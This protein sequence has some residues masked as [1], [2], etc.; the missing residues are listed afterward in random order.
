MDTDVVVVGAGAAGLAAALWLAE[1]SVRVIVL[2]GRNN[3]GGRVMWQSLGT[4]DVPAEL[5]AEFVHGAAPETSALLRD[6][7][8]AKV[9]TGNAAWLC[10]SGRALRLDDDDIDS[11]AIFERAHS[12][13]ED[14]SVD[15]FLRRWEDDPR[16]REQARRA[17]AFVEGFEAADPGLASIRSIADEIRMGSDSTSSRPVGGYAPLFEHLTARC[18]RAGVDV[19]LGMVVERIAWKTGDVTIAAQTQ[20]G[21]A[22]EFRSRC[23]VITVPVGVLRAAGDANRFSFLPPLPAAKQAALRG[24]EMGH[25]VRVTLAFRSP[26]WEQAD[27]GRYRDAAFFRCEDGAFS[28]FWTQM[29]LRSRTIVA[30]AGGPRAT[31]LNGTPVQERIDRARDEFGAIFGQRDLARREYEAGVTHDWSTDPLAC[32]AYTYVATGAGAARAALGAPVDDTLFFAGEATSTDGQGGTVSGAFG[33]GMR[34][35]REAAR[36]FGIAGAASQSVS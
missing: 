32:G 36:A 11:R 22:S 20:N 5:G 1:R 29:P 3:V 14:E 28:A 35:A 21:G 24:L 25:A 4:A 31:A 6:A 23:A 8:L 18:V 17:R 33:T 19:R 10:S 34:A 2:E 7:G 26:F 9:E 27:D 12:L 15:V 13:T 30:W 16:M